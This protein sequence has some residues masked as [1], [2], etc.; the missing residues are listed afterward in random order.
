[1]QSF[2][3]FFVVLLFFDNA[4]NP[5]FLEIRPHIDPCVLLNLV[6]LLLTILN[7]RFNPSSDIMLLFRNE[8]LHLRPFRY[9]HLRLLH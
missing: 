8:L 7:L 5:L 6:D 9:V 4:F 2:F 1:M 3:A